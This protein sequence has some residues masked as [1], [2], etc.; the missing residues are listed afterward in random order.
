MSKFFGPLKLFDG[1]VKGQNQILVHIKTF[2]TDQTLDPLK[3]PLAFIFFMKQFGISRVVFRDKKHSFFHYLVSKN[4]FNFCC[5]CGTKPLVQ[6]AFFKDLYS[7]I[8]MNMSSC[9]YKQFGVYV[10]KCSCV[11]RFIRLFVYLVVV[12]VILLLQQHWLYLI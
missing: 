10:S 2:Q 3:W 11:T 12:L 5:C 7:K 8:W 4:I 9:I 1:E 6:L